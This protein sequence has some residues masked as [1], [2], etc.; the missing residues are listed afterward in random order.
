MPSSVPDKGFE[1]GSCVL[2]LSNPESHDL[3][4]TISFISM[5]LA[6]NL[7]LLR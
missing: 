6:L 2:A 5:P 7:F 4:V 3:S 1:S